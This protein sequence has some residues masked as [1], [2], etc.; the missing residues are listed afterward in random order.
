MA[1]GLEVLDLHQRFGDVVAL[2]GVGFRVD[3]GEI[4]GFVGRKRRRQP[5]A[6]LGQ[7]PVGEHPARLE[8]K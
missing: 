1:G 4:V 3:G 5:P 2:D 8:P 6:Q 7:R